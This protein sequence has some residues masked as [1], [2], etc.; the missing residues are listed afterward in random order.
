[1][2]LL[3]FLALNLKILK[4]DVAYDSYGPPSKE[5]AGKQV[6]HIKICA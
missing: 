5:E 2:A 1:M 3:P 6:S 4:E